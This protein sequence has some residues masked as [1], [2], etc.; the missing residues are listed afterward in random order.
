[1]K[2]L[3]TG[4]AGYIGGHCVYELVRSGY[5]VVILD[6][7]STGNVEAIHKD[8]ILYEGDM[9]DGA[10]LDKIM[11]E[12]KIDAV[13]HFAAKLI[14]PESVTHPI[15]YY[16]NNVGG[17]T[18]VLDAMKRNDVKR[19]VFSSTAAVYGTP[20]KVPCTEDDPTRPE[21]PYGD[22]KLACE[23]LIKWAA[24]AHDFQYVIFRYF[25]VAG[26]DASGTIG[27]ASKKITHLI[28]SI[29]EAAQGIRPQFTLY[30]DDYPTRDGT[31]IRDYIHVTDLVK[32]HIKGLEYMVNDGGSGT[33]N[34]GT[35]DGSSNKEIVDAVE[36][37]IGQK[38]PLVWGP[39]RAGDPA[40]IVASNEKAQKIL[41]WT[42][43]HNLK[44][45]IKS[46]YDFRKNHPHGYK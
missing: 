46:D 8:A 34:L 13:L 35:N 45:I 41:G 15:E 5:E 22:S 36:E 14:V 27:L 28:P 18:S 44:D 11:T 24:A 33:F 1:M 38:I 32:A 43:E 19:I 17:V 12:H 29:I 10:I 6:N 37:V 3:V 31:C 7:L 21:S 25:N 23:G 2:V 16:N 26:G 39:R 40:M 20:E 42:P 4:G 9:R 30:G